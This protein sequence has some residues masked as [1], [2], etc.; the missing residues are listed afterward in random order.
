VSRHPD[1]FL[2]GAPKCGTTAMHAYLARHPQIFMPKFKEIHYY[3]SDLSGLATQL[4]EEMHQS[5]FADV[6]GTKR[7]GETCI[8]ALYSRKAATEIK[9][10]VD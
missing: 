10:L 1:F 2:V 4:T 3:G 5:L 9:D 6:S 8:W 7:I